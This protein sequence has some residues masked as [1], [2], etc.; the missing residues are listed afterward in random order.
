[1]PAAAPYRRHACRR[2]FGCRISTAHVTVCAA[3]LPHALRRSPRDYAS[4]TQ[5]LAA[6]RENDSYSHGPMPPYAGFSLLLARHCCARRRHATRHAPALS[7]PQTPPACCAT[8]L[9]FF[10]LDTSPPRRRLM[11]C[12]VCSAHHASGERRLPLFDA[13]PLPPPPSSPDFC[14]DFRKNDATPRASRPRRQRAA[15]IRHVT[16]SFVAVAA[17]RSLFCRRR[18]RRLIP[19]PRHAA[20]CAVRLLRAMPTMLREYY[21][22]PV[23]C[24][25]RPA[26]MRAHVIDELFA[27]VTLH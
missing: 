9:P 27:N 26:L 24:Y 1:M 19:E 2:R 10:S 17:I 12:H 15:T 21:F 20:P 16:R 18:R 14:F 22:C 8:C 6:M 13:A 25:A 5:A 4:S 23:R 11:R 7:A 3:C